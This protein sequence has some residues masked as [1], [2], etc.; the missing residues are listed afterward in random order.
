MTRQL[1]Y[2]LDNLSK[3]MQTTFTTPSP[4]TLLS[5]SYGSASP[6]GYKRGLQQPIIPG[7]NGTTPS[8]ISFE[9]AHL[10]SMGSGPSPEDLLTHHQQQQSRGNMPLHHSSLIQFDEEEVR[11]P[12][13]P[14]MQSSSSIRLEDDD[15]D[16][17]PVM[18]QQVF[19]PDGDN[20]MAH[21]S[22]S[23]FAERPPPSL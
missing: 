8:S 18:D 11:L 21:P 13:T 7:N 14:S 9:D 5:G 12:V 19:S 22:E 1:M 23:I 15:D 4:T 10:I 2:C 6:A 17:L 20:E 3:A 16:N